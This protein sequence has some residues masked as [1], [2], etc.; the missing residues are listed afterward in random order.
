MR[1]PMIMEASEA[2]SSDEGLGEFKAV[3]ACEGFVDGGVWVLVAMS[4]LVVVVDSVK[5]AVKE[6]NEDGTGDC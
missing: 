1:V 6:G 2:G 4:K 3:V 5:V